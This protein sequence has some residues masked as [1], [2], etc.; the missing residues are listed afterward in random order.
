MQKKR[1]ENFL[2]RGG[3]REKRVDFCSSQEERRGSSAD[4]SLSCCAKEKRKG[5]PQ[6]KS[7]RALINLWHGPPGESCIGQTGWISGLAQK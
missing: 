2:L 3:F 4:G 7:F 6:R 1:D 5:F